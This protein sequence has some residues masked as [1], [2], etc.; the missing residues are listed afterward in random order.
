MFGLTKN[1]FWKIDTSADFRVHKHTVINR[2]KC[3]Q[4]PMLQNSPKSNL[5]C[6]ILLVLITCRYLLVRFP[7]QTK[8]FY[9]LTLNMAWPLT[10]INYVTALYFTHEH[11]NARIYTNF[12]QKKKISTKDC[13]STYLHGKC[14]ELLF[15]TLYSWC[16]PV[17]IKLC[18][19]H[20]KQVNNPLTGP[21][22]SQPSSRLWRE[23]IKSK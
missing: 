9:I 6:C 11:N 20:R 22:I 18:S 7:C 16:H 12:H 21:L 8:M 10:T 23:R 2:T 15:C 17:P 4:I 3:S 5:I 13:T 1:K 14:C 19:C